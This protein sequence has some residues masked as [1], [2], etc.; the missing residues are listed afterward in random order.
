[1]DTQKHTPGPWRVEHTGDY[2]DDPVKVVKICYPDGQQRHLAKVYDCYLPGDGDGDANAR[3]IAAAP[4]ML[5][6]LEAMR[7]AWDME[8]RESVRARGEA[9]TAIRAAIAKARGES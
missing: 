2:A 4:D 5:A 9:M 7:D 3:L 8:G 1:M 6:A